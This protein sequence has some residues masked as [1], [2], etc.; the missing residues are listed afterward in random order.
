MIDT[1][2][3]IPYTKELDPYVNGEGSLE[4]Q[5][6]LETLIVVPRVHG[7]SERQL[8]HVAR[9]EKADFLEHAGE[10]TGCE[11]T[12]R[13]TKNTDFISDAI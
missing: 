12:T 1:L 6:Q 11:S 5:A 4:L 8:F 9:R 7:V 3:V 13:E 2:D 10:R